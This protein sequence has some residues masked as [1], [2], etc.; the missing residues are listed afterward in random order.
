M[1]KILSLKFT[2]L[3]FLF[4][5]SLCCVSQVCQAKTAW[6]PL[7]KATLLGDDIEFYES[8]LRHN[9][10]ITKVWIYLPSRR[11]ENVRLP[12]VLIA[13]AGTSL[14]HGMNLAIGDRKE[15]LP[16]VR[17]GFAV[18]AYTVSGFL[19]GEG[20]KEKVVPAARLFQKS[21]AGL[22]NA[23]A[24]L[25][26]ALA[27]V[28]QIDSKRIYAAGH[29]SAGTTA[30]WVASAEKRV[31]ACVAY[32][33]VGDVPSRLSGDMSLFESWMPG[34]AEFLARTSPR[35]NVSR[36]KKPIFLFHAQDDN[37]VKTKDIE[38][39]YRAVKNV[40]PN[41]TL[42]QVPRGGHY[43]SMIRDGIPRGIAWLQ[44][45]SQ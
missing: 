32:A 42:Q 33:P 35:S 37:N 21:Q 4:F 38:T 13:P 8:K 5:L 31:A 39:F 22:L 2:Q 43:Y 16:Y 36:L 30:L 19:S 28:P 27:R 45:L 34:F 6:P 10:L 12:C 20:T 17:A 18:I 1:K 29:S 40:N 41:V 44:K 11:D 14:W 23:K 9:G 26:F 24:A 25:D 7:G 15:Q 3:S